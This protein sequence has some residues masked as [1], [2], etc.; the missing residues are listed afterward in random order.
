M[1]ARWRLFSRRAREELTMAGNF[2]GKKQPIVLCFCSIF[3]FFL[4]T[5]SQSSRDVFF[6]YFWISEIGEYY[7]DAFTWIARIYLFFSPTYLSYWKYYTGRGIHETKLGS[8]CMKMWHKQN[9][10]PH[11][12][13]C[14]SHCIW[15]RTEYTC[16]LVIF[17]CLWGAGSIRAKNFFVQISPEWSFFSLSY[18]SA[19]SSICR[20]GWES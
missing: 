15:S 7:S 8:N 13:F 19:L 1:L 11:S 12:D 18:L 9:P 4:I 3:I 20:N 2:Y 6:H 16:S 10:I 17:C 5:Q 14:K